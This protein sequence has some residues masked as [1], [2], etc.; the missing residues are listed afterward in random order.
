MNTR[1][2]ALLYVQMVLVLI[3]LLTQTGLLVF[4]I[5][6]KLNA[7]MIVSYVVLIIAHLGAVVYGIIGYKKGPSRYII[8]VS[9][10]LLAIL[11]NIILPFRDIAQRVL[12]TLLFG[13]MSIF[14]FKQKDYKFTNYLILVAAILAL[15][16]S[17]YSAITA[18]MDSLGEV[19]Y[20]KLGVVMMY[21]SI[22]APVMFTGFFGVSY[23]VKYSNANQ[24]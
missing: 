3:G 15:T 4:A 22:F 7:I 23:N 8:L 10:F 6:N 5:V 9:L 17:I 19:T 12:L 2:K 13:A 18:N 11:L 21:L 1:L 14:M 24:Q 20:K 16:F